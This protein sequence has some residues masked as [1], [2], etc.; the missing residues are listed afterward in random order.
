MSLK[1]V[2]L[3]LGK[4]F[5]YS[6]LPPPDKKKGEGMKEPCKCLSYN[7]SYLNYLILGKLQKMLSSQVP[8]ALKG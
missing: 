4:I 3:I 6:C 7:F 8:R 5:K 2:G 1:V